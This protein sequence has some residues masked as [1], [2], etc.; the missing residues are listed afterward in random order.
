MICVIPILINE[1]YKFDK[2]IYITKWDAADVLAY[3]GSIVAAFGAAIGVFVSIKYSHKQYQEDKR[4]DVMPYFS[5]NILGRKCVDPFDSS[6]YGVD[7]SNQETVEEK[8]NYREFLCDKAFFIF[9][10][11][12]IEYAVNL[13]EKQMEAVKIVMKPEDVEQYGELFPNHCG[14]IP[15]DLSNVGNGCAVN[16]T[17]NISSAEKNIGACS[18]PISIPVG[19]KFYTGVLME[20][21]NSLSG[22]F[23]Y[24]ILCYDI[25]GN[26]YSHHKTIT[27]ANGAIRITKETT[28]AIEK[29]AKR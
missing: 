16:T 19:G 4:R 29:E 21:E 22:E 5:V 14:Y 26:Q 11:N 9:S 6:W 15:L 18:V 13:S 2:I 3:Y 12:K 10:G 8:L 27:I 17:I 24:R 1:F 20:T 23:D 25:Y 7:E 28:H